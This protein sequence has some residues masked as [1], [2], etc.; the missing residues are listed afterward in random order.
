GGGGV[1]RGG[2]GVGP[3]PWGR[4]PSGGGGGVRVAP[5]AEG[6][7]AAR[8]G[9]R[10][11]WTLRRAGNKPIRTPLDWEAVL[12]DAR[13]GEPLD[14]VFG[15]GDRERSVRL[16]PEDLP[17]VTAERIRALADFELIT[18]T[19]AIRAER[20]LVSERGALIVSLS[21]VARQIGLREGDLIVQ[22]N[23]VP[24][25]NGEQA[26]RLLQRLAGQGPIRV[27]IERQG[28]LRSVD[29]YIRG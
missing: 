22:I 28:R 17:S 1:R 7:P 12:L 13:V 2:G 16:T 18:L 27:F 5:V 8:A 3:G 25:E 29:F 26:A 10:P 23:R 15:D 24:I 6:W 9:V 4:G 11:G 20:G 14:I 19:P 21:P